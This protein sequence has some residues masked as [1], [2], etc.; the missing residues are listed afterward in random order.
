MVLLVAI[1]RA[2]DYIFQEKIRAWYLSVCILWPPHDY[3]RNTSQ[4]ISGVY[5][6]FAL[7][8]R[9]KC[10]SNLYI[11]FL[12]V[13][14][15]LSRRILDFFVPFKIVKLIVIP[16]FKLKCNCYFT[17]FPFI[18]LLSYLRLLGNIFLL[19]LLIIYLHHN[20]GLTR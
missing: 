5:I 8:T 7:D 11:A 13:F 15:I 2:G 4:I 6:I 19:W 3:V 18:S 14:T 10:E 16:N 20:V 9:T 12:F 1:I 17:L